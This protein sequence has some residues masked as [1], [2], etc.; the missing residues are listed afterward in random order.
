M[1]L[2]LKMSILMLLSFDALASKCN[3]D[4][5]NKLIKE[6]SSL[7]ECHVLTGLRSRGPEEL[8]LVIR[9]ENKG[10]KARGIGLEIYENGVF[11]KRLFEDYGLG[12]AL[13]SFYKDGKKEKFLFED[14]DKDGV[15]EFGLS[16]LNERTALFFIYTF[17]DKS[18]KFDSVNFKQ[19]INGKSE[20]LDRLVASLDFPLKIVSN[21]IHVH[22]DKDKF[23]IYRFKD[24][25]FHKVQ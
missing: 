7:L 12:Q 13:G 21:A 17:N 5:M 24:G 10:K 6:N 11:K 1:K 3:Q 14:F 18:K 8:I 15:K 16:V 9:N 25:E 19:K 22:H 4:M 20:R 23:I 2:I